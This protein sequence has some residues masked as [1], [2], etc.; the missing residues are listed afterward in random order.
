M[1]VWVGVWLV[2]R[3][4]ADFGFTW[5]HQCKRFI[6]SIFCHHVCMVRGGGDTLS[7]FTSVFGCKSLFQYS[8]THANLKPWN[9]ETLRKDLVIV[10]EETFCVQQKTC[11]SS[12]I[13]S[14]RILLVALYASIRT[15]LKL[16][17]VAK[18]IIINYV[19]CY[20][21]SFDMLA[22]SSEHSQMYQAVI[23]SVLFSATHLCLLCSWRKTGTFK[24]NQSVKTE[25]ADISRES[26]VAS[27]EHRME[28]IKFL[29]LNK[30]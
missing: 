6:F 14:M 11:E 1:I 7:L 29:W 8:H 2:T 3:Y 23:D 21:S 15:V 19:S 24:R 22:F 20:C 25:P 17:N 28:T 10:M 12:S 26:L 5:H 18:C 13:V 30:K 16:L 27:L 9:L 4:C